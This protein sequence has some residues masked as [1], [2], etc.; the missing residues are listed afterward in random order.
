MRKVLVWSKQSE[1]LNNPINIFFFWE[2]GTLRQANNLNWSASDLTQIYFSSLICVSV[3]IFD[4]QI[5]RPTQPFVRLGPKNCMTFIFLFCPPTGGCSISKPNLH[6]Q[7]VEATSNKSQGGSQIGWLG[8]ILAQIFCQSVPL[9]QII[10]SKLYQILKLKVLSIY[11]TSS[12]VKRTKQVY[13]L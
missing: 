5:F 3:H 4:I 7:R 6:V 2:G 13:L 9:S 1:E 11:I 8:E 10:Q 12:R